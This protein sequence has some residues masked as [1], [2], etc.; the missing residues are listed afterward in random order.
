MSPA[1]R[2]EER[3]LTLA[4]RTNVD[5]AASRHIAEL[6]G[7][8]I[9]PEQLWALGH[10][11]EVMPLLWRTLSAPALAPLVDSAL[12]ERLRRRYYATLI[13]N[14]SRRA[15]LARLITALAAQGIE[16]IPVKGPWLAVEAYGSAALRTFDDLDLLIR[17]DDIDGARRVMEQRAYV[18]RRVPRFEEAHHA[19]HD[20]Q[21]FGTVDGAEQCV[22]LHWA[23]WS[24]A[25][26]DGDPAE[27]WS[28]ARR[29]AV[30]DVATPVLSAEDAILHLAIH[31]TASALRL[32][33]VSDVAE[34]LRCHPD[35]DWDAL[36]TRATAWRARTATFVALDLA[37]RLLDAPV[38][39][40]VLRRLRI[41][42]L[43][44][45]VLERTCGVRAL[46]RDVA[47]ED[48]KQQPRLLYRVVEQDGVGHIVAA[49]LGKV[50][51][52]PAKWHYARHATDA[53][54]V[55]PA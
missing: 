6:L 27:L 33:F 14:E 54:K 46:F 29:G 35:L 4:A 2:R 23:L 50:R 21:W 24:P 42:R 44:R 16:A 11:H 48:V 12:L 28:R 5:E 53:A 47:A 51:R 7:A 40:D 17:P 31:R 18:N 49:A 43:K 34:L 36:V 1:L 30:L 8:G 38:P 37:R 22:E 19:F 45:I 41:P 10:R 20:L 13:R 26:F 15:E 25:Q 9:D 39:D 52:K 55:R 32:R 3:L